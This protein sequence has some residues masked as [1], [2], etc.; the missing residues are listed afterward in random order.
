[1]Y[2]T[3]GE[4]IVVKDE[5]VDIL[6]AKL[7]A[8]DGIF[9]DFEIKIQG[10]SIEMPNWTLADTSDRLPS[11]F[12]QEGTLDNTLV[13]YFP[14]GVPIRLVFRVD[15]NNLGVFDMM[16]IC[17]PDDHN[18]ILTIHFNGLFKEYGKPDCIGVNFQVQMDNIHIFHHVPGEEPELIIT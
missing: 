5:Q 4:W 7:L 12:K 11:G 2:L 9:V 13:S 18:P 17:F 8:I 10:V 1:M 15:A 16:T 14:A 6:T 3:P